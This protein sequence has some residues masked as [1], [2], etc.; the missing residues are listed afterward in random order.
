MEVQLLPF[1][2]NKEGHVSSVIVKH[3]QPDQ[4]SEKT[5]ENDSEAAHEACAADILKAIEAKDPK[6][7]AS[8]LR[9]AF[10]IMESEPHEEGPHIEPHSYEAQNE[11]A[12]E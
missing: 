12:A 9:S 11:K 10:E 8:A 6:A 3:R 1:L 2:K 5:E 7:L 4:P